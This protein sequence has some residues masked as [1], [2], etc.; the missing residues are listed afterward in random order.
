MTSPR[1]R[2][3]RTCTAR[4]SR[5]SRRSSRQSSRTR[6]RRPRRGS[7]PADTVGGSGTCSRGGGTPPPRARV[8]RGREAVEDPAEVDPVV[9]HPGPV[10]SERVR[11]VNQASPDV[12]AALVPRGLV[13]PTLPP[14]P[15]VLRVE[16]E[17]LE[18]VP[19]LGPEAAGEDL[20]EGDLSAQPADVL[21]AAHDETRVH[22]EVLLRADVGLC[23]R[24]E[25][26][27]PVRQGDRPES[28]DEGGTIKVC[29]PAS[30]G[31]DGPGRLGTSWASRGGPGSTSPRVNHA[32]EVALGVR[33]DHEV[34]VSFAGAE[35]GRAEGEETVHFSVGGV[36]R[37]GEGTRG[38]SG[39]GPRT[40]EG[41]QGHAVDEIV[42][43]LVHEDDREGHGP[44]RLLGVTDRGLERLPRRKG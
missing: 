44:A 39:D 43:R 13:D 14:L 37:P 34:L 23:I 33:E 12:L 35:H 30:R 9:V 7:I 17:A 21:K 2:T 26:I 25:L 6:R 20:G 19:P 32:E 8:R 1:G 10:A 28:T 41:A 40:D 3:S 22:D 27:V 11:D 16:D 5:Q 38:L 42:P 29:G 36:R 31:I 15:L 4:G 18:D 24:E